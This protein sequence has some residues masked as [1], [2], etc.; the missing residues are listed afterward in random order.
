MILCVCFSEDEN[1]TYENGTFEISMCKTF[2]SEELKQVLKS[3]IVNLI[4]Y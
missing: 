3:V 4:S 1:Q 2:F